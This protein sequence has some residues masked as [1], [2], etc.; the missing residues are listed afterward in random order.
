MRKSVQ[1]IGMLRFIITFGRYAAAVAVV[2]FSSI[3][4]FFFI[5]LIID[6]IGDLGVS[7]GSDLV[8]YFWQTTF[9][10][11]GFSGVVAGSLCLKRTNRRGGSIILLALGL[12]YYLWLQ[13][14]IGSLSL[15]NVLRSDFS[16]VEIVPLA[17]GGLGAVIVAFR[18]W[19]KSSIVNRKFFTPVRD[20]P[21]LCRAFLPF[22]IPPRGR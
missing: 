9:L 12:V 4:A 15:N 22:P 17:L 18:H 10:A 14:D 16:P 6:C 8:W 20:N 13:S 1:Y 21:N 19:R 11:A 7:G 5:L 2:F 3:A